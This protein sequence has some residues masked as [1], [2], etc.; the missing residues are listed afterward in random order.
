MQR[1]PQKKAKQKMA[2]PKALTP[3]QVVQLLIDR[4][5]MSYREL[6]LLY[7]ISKTTAWNYCSRAEHSP[8][9]SIKEDSQSGVDAIKDTIS[10]FDSLTFSSSHLFTTPDEYTHGESYISHPGEF[11][12]V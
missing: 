1:K 4:D 5:S 6:G 11:E 7:N 12:S 3:S 8:K 9:P 10:I 2:R